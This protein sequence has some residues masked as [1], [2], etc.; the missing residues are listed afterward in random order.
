MTFLNFISE[1]GDDEEAKKIT[2][3]EFFK[4]VAE[5]RSELSEKLVSGGFEIK[6]RPIKNLFEGDFF[7]FPRK[8]SS[9]EEL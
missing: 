7:G 1:K 8:T 6:P 4:K 2:K 5:T 9:K 3:L